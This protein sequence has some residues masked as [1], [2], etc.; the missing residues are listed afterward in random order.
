MHV[1]FRSL[2]NTNSPLDSIEEEVENAINENGPT[3]DSQDVNISYDNIA[4]KVRVISTSYMYPWNYCC[5][6]FFFFLSL[7]LIRMCMGSGFKRNL[8]SSMRTIMSRIMKCNYVSYP[9]TSNFD[10]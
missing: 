10:S 8:K 7:H 1:Q 4:E 2:T 9:R 5:I 6:I 3:E